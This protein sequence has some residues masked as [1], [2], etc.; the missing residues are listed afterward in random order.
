MACVACGARHMARE[1][2][3]T[4]VA[5]GV[6]SMA[7]YGVRGAWRARR[8]ACVREACGAWR[9]MA[10]GAWRARREARGASGA[11]HAAYGAQEM[12][13]RTRT[14]AASSSA[15]A[16][17]ARQLDATAPRSTRSS[18]ATTAACTLA[19]SSTKKP[20]ASATFMSR[21]PTGSL[22]RP[23]PLKP[24]ST[25]NAPLS[26]LTRAHAQSPSRPLAATRAGTFG[27]CGAV[28]AVVLL[29]RR[30]SPLGDAGRVVWMDGRV[31]A[32]PPNRRALCGAGRRGEALW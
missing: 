14:M 28:C 17:S 26:A 19:G 1:A 31:D 12:A 16:R 7:A 15:I 21:L 4:R 11:R 20:S 2:H 13:H 22:L 24:P 29:R 6:W 10:C 27:D 30:A 9:H 3:D 18:S 32:R 23:Q 8:T 5:R 25:V